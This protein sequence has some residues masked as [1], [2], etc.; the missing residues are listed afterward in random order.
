MCAERVDGEELADLGLVSFAKVGRRLEEH[1]AAGDEAAVPESVA[2]AE[3]GELQEVLTIEQEHL[4]HGSAIH[5]RP[6][7]KLD[8]Q[9]LRA[10]ARDGELRD[11]ARTLDHDGGRDLLLRALAICLDL[12]S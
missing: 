4:G 1:P 8:I 2:A 11:D 9:E 12:K 3:V 7:V 5:S 10:R 6:V